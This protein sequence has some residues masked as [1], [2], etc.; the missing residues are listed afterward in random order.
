MKRAAPFLD[1][2]C[3]LAVICVIEAAAGAVAG[4]I[5]SGTQPGAFSP[6]M[7][8]QRAMGALHLD[9]VLD[10][11]DW[12]RAEPVVSFTQ[13]FPAEGQAATESTEVRILY[14]DEHLYIGAL[15]LDRQIGSIIA[16]E[17]KED[18][19]LDNDDSFAV[20]IDTFHDRRNGYFFQ[21]NPLGA[22]T[23]ALIFD[24]GR[25]NSFDWD[26]VWDVAARLTENGWAL[27]MVIP[28]K[29]LHFDPEET[30]PWGLQLRRI[31]RRDAEDAFWAPIP[32]NEDEWRMSR[33]GELTGLQGIR[34]GRD[35]AVKPYALG[36]VQERPSFDQEAADGRGDV[37]LDAR[38]A[39]TP[40]LSAI[41]TINTDFAETEVDDQQ[42]NLTRFPLFFPEKR[43]FFLESKGYFDFGYKRPGGGTPIGVIPFFSRRIGLK[44]TEIDGAAENVPVPILG[45]AKMAGRMGR[46]NLGF[47]TAE[48]AEDGGTPQTNVTALR[49]SRDIL[50]RSNWGVIGAAKS[51]EGPDEPASG[52]HFNAT[53][54]ADLNFSLMQ[55]LRL[56]GALLQTRTPDMEGGEGMGRFYTDWSNNDW[57]MEFSYTDIGSGFNPEVGFVQRVGIEEVVNF[58][59]WSWRS[60]TGWV[61]RIEP[62][63]RMTY[64]MD[65][66]RDVLTRWQHW[67]T[68]FEFRDGSSLE[69][70]WNPSFDELQDTFELREDIVVPPGAYHPARWFL[71]FEGD[72][73]RFLSANAFIE[74][75]DFFDGTIDS[76]TTEGNA[77]LSAHVK[78][79]LG[80]SWNEIRLPER[81]IPS[82]VRPGSPTSDLPASELTTTLVQTRLGFTFTTRVYFDALLQYNTDVD[83]FSSNLRFNYKYRPGSDI[84]VVYNERRDIEGLP[85]DVV[86]RSF[87]VKWTYLMTF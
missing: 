79:G 58:L 46:Y 47:L 83:D 3:L 37:G 50:S 72:E 10:E 17:M 12:G 51:P 18:A 86:D 36:G 64:T 28:F 67:A 48:T 32:R 76:I 30:N 27:E 84:Y 22:R 49:V 1:T 87:T 62:H 74:S 56:G 66:D 80:V 65:Q 57:D 45:G 69:L 63:F 75:G 35:F 39:V 2:C 54:G 85:T 15:L 44:E 38:Y 81:G 7:R 20:F 59:G 11:A 29:T 53:Y 33:A 13:R 9:G 41:L 21:T 4:E 60:A 31:I 73:S 23:D 70:A 24:E 14:D 19:E 26:G 61:R 82:T 16:R 5:P 40:N 8:A 68:T 42:V 43:E 71:H 34:Q 52:E 25:N 77:R 55:N 78:A 6:V